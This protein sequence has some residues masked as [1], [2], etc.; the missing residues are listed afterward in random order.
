MLSILIPT[1]NYNAFPLVFDLEQQAQ[2][3]EIEYEIICVDDASNS[4]FNENNEKI[5][6]LEGCTFKELPKNIGRSAIRNLL[7]EKA[8]YECLLFIDAGTFPKNKDFIKN[9]LAI[10]NKKVISGGMTY[11]DK[12]PKKPYKLRWLYTKKRESNSQKKHSFKPVICS[13][14]F[15][16]KKDVI[17]LNPFDESLKK[18][19]YEDVLFFDS[20]IKKKIPIHC[21]NNPVIHNADD[22]AETFIIKTENAIENLI[23]LIDEHK[24][25]S[26][27]S[28]ISKLYDKLKK[29]KLSRLILTL[30]KVVKPLLKKNFNSTYPSI[31][32]YD[33]YRLGYFCQLKAKE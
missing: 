4:P 11:L 20:I 31:F 33:F 24:I 27:L 30:F 29:I 32:L 5:N 9:Y 1:Y 6:S 14:N 23:Y 7:A 2:K 3:A 13:S 15:F 19:G 10:K 26:D 21:F 16:I 25:K 17:K 28:S 22:N 8:Q 12:P 18:Y